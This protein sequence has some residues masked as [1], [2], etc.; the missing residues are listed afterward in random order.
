MEVSSN[1]HIE[2]YLLWYGTYEENEVITMQTLL[3]PTAVVVD[4]GANIGYY[5]LMAAVKAT[6]GQV[7]SFEP[8]TKSFQ[9]LNRN[10]SLNKFSSIHTF[11]VAISDTNGHTTIYVSADDNSGMSGMKTAENF[12]GESETVQCLTL[13]EAVIQYNLPKI[14]LIKIDVEGAEINVLQGMQQIRAK[15][16]PV[17]LIEASKATLAMYN[18]RIESIYE[19]LY[20]DQYR[21]YRVTGINILE[22]ITIPS[23]GDLVFFVPEHYTF[24][25]K[26]QLK[27]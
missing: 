2:K 5:S 25:E 6:T 13:D 19:I 23:E 11:Q 7:Y 10:I 14:D 26:I 1:D 22:K 17:I 4:I 15:Q 8:V 3:G 18:E 20:A 24:P 16:K 12:S 27:L 9:Q 21:S